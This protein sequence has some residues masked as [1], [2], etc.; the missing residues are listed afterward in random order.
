MY[1]I[2]EVVKHSKLLLYADDLKL[3]RE[4]NNYRDNQLLQDDLNSI[5]TWCTKNK[6]GVNAL[7]TKFISFTNKTQYYVSNYKINKMD[8]LKVNTIKDLGTHFD[9]NLKFN[10]HITRITGE[11]RR[12]IGYIFN[13]WSEFANIET[14]LTLYKTLVRA[15]LEYATS[16]WNDLTKSSNNTIE[17]VQ[18][19][20]IRLLCYKV[21]LPYYSY[22]YS[23]WCNTFKLE[24][25]EQRRKNIDKKFLAKIL[26]NTTQSSY[27]IEKL[28]FNIPLYNTRKHKLVTT[29]DKGA[30]LLNRIIHNF[31]E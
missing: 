5:T 7:K 24:T 14:Y 30:V 23:Y 15:K 10:F 4:V 26:D 28:S 27:F 22:D 6:I 2:S 18:K 29:F 8:V 1:D 25:L 21:N 11:A 16:V 19:S 13:Q 12:L 3:Y 17:S 31:N 9:C 20:F